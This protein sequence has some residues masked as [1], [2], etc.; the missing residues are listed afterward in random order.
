MARP[1]TKT[2]SESVA[3]YVKKTYNRIE[4]KV[5]KEVAA[6]F[7]EKCKAEGTNPNRIINEWIRG[8]IASSD[9]Q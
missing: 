8:Y 6:E 7:R 3:A 2:A 1:K 5:P 9:S 4:T